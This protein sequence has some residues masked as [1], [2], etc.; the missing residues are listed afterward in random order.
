MTRA[1]APTEPDVEPPAGL[2]RARVLASAAMGT[3]L[4]S[5]A[6]LVPTT[7]ILVHTGGSGFSLDGAFAATVPLWLAAHQVPLVVQGQPLSVLPLLPTAAVIA[8]IAMGSTWA[9]RRLGGRAA[10]DGGAVLATVG[11]AHTT[12]AVLAT[13]LLPAAVSAG[14]W[15]AMPAAALVAVPAAGLGVVRACGV[16]EVVDRLRQLPPWVLPGLRGAVVGVATLA[17]I[18]AAVLV[19]GLVMAV[20]S[21]HAAFDHLAPTVS[22]GLGVTLLAFL[23]LPNAVVAAASWGF[24]PGVGVGLAWASPF[25][26]VPGAEVS[27]FPLLAAMPLTAPLWA[28]LVLVGPVLGGVLVGRACVRF[29]GQARPVQRV[30]SALLAVGVTALAAGLLALVAGGRL[31]A[32]TYDPVRVPALWFMLGVLG[33]MGLPAVAAAAMQVP[34][35]ASGRAVELIRARREAARAAQVPD[36]R[37]GPDAGT[38]AGPAS[39]AVP[40]PARSEAPAATSGGGEGL[41]AQDPAP[42]GAVE[43]AAAGDTGRAAEAAGTAAAAGSAAQDSAAEDTASARH[44]AAVRDDGAAASSG[45]AASAEPVAGEAAGGAVG[46]AARDAAASGSAG[47]EAAAE[48]PASGH[49]GDPV[50]PRKA[51]RFSRIFRRTRPAADTTADTTADTPPASPEAAASA[52]PAPQPATGAESPVLPARAGRKRKAAARPR[53]VADLVAERAARDVD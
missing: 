30:W 3:I 27:S 19:G 6:I 4:V 21:V 5:Y 9:V 14:P 40:D 51:G 28:L 2:D 29:G 17:V 34:E 11:G 43:D 15:M 8:V 20:G 35:R 53:T 47:A 23:Y 24:G 41:P 13:A 36:Q 37:T 33:W 32:G 50:P 44:E 38:E 39:D 26:T 48:A 1:I 42:A 46:T 49:P 31:A 7:A 22:A 45:A 16:D 52:D 12:V 18:G 10:H 25:T